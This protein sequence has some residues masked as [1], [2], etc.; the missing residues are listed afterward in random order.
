MYQRFIAR[1]DVIDIVEDAFDVIV[2]RIEEEL[3][4]LTYVPLDVGD[5]IT[6]VDHQPVLTVNHLTQLFAREMGGSSQPLY[7]NVRQW[8][9]VLYTNSKI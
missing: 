5:L 9:G 7:N 1:K 2:E 4:F 3:V 8:H 6:F